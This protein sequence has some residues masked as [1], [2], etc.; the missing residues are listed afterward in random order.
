M[1]DQAI[2]RNRNRLVTLRTLLLLALCCVVLYVGAYIYMTRTA[3]RLPG[4]PEYY[5]FVEPTN[6][7]DCE[8]NRFYYRLFLPLVLIEV[9]INDNWLSTGNRPGSCPDFK[10]S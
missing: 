9:Y 7:D 10:I 6:E 4:F 1:S 3:F 2:L 8:R 5:Y